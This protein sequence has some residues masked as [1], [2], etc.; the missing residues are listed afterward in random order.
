MN[1]ASKWWEELEPW[2]QE[3]LAFSL[4]QRTFGEISFIN[5][6]CVHSATDVAKVTVADT[7]KS[8]L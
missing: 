4:G 8:V 1:L 7:M 3:L 5:V 2:L 6:A